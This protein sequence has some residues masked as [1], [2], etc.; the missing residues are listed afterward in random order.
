MF[1]ALE[2]VFGFDRWRDQL[3]FELESRP[4]N[5]EELRTRL[6]RLGLDPEYRCQLTSN[7]NVFVSYSANA[8]RLHKGYLDAPEETWKAIV[9]FVSTKSRV[10]RRAARKKLLEYDV[11]RGQPL[12]PRVHPPRRIHP[13]DEAM[14]ERLRRAHESFNKEKFNGELAVIPILVSRRMRSRLGHYT[15]RD[16]SGGK[17]EIVISRRHVRRHG[18]NDA[19]ETLIHEMI[20]QWQDESG[21]AID[22]G[23]EFR[24]KAREVGIHPRARTALRTED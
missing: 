1:R 5:A 2:R 22:H 3:S 15:H 23:R 20:H 13:D 14:A 12:A 24:A 18:W 10:K 8:L 7:R 11:H 17:S 16:P 4:R 19:L 9:E 6:V 21:R